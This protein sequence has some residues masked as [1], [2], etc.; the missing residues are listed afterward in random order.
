MII[1][2]RYRDIPKEEVGSCAKEFDNWE[3]LRGKAVLIGERCTC[4]QASNDCGQPKWHT[5][6]NTRWL[7][8][9]FV[10]IGD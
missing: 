10:E 1:K 8:G 7:C 6:D 9:C 2:T 3:E 4:R 5:P